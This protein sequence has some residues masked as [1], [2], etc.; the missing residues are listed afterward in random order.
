VISL[1]PSFEE[2]LVLPRSR[3]DTYK[4]LF[5]STSQKPFRQPDEHELLFSGWVLPDRMRISLRSMR[6]AHFQPLVEGTLEAS[7][8]GCIMLLRYA[9]FPSTR[10]LIQF[11]SLLI[12]L[13]SVITSYTI[14]SY[15]VSLVGLGLLIMIYLIA[16]SNFQ[17]HLR[18]TRDAIH[19]VVA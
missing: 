4:R 3:E 15:T 10:L 9:L 17:L 11:W 1:L 19:R 18:T 13:G 2:T 7:S 8:S 12:V 6:P 14:R 5:V 16:W